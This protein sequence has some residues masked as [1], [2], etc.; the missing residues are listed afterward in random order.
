[1]R[2]ASSSAV[3]PSSLAAFSRAAPAAALGRTGRSE[4]AA[5]LAK[6]LNEADLVSLAHE[7]YEKWLSDGAQSK[8]KWVLSFAAAFGGP[9]MTPKL[10]RA[11]HDWPQHARGAISRIH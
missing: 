9:A 6:D 2:S 3:M 11:I 8:T 1:M 10:T 4:T 7:V 5:E